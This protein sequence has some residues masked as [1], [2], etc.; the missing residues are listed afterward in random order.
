G[1]EVKDKDGNA[2]KYGVDGS[3]I[4]GADGK[5]AA[6]T[7]AGSTIEDEKGNV[8][9]T[10]ATGTNVTAQNGNSAH[11]GAEGVTVN[12]P[13]GKPVITLV[14][15]DNGPSLNFAKG[16]DGQGTGKIT[17]VANGDISPESSDVVTGGQLYS[18][19]KALTGGNE[20]TF[21]PDGSTSTTAKDKDGNPILDKDG[22]PKQYTL[23]TYNVE[24]QSEFVTNSVITAVHNMN[25]QG[26]KFFHTN[27]NVTKSVSQAK[28]DIDS[29]ASGAYAT[30]VGYQ[31]S[32]S[33]DQSLAIGHGA[34]ASG[35]QSL[36]IGTGNQVSGNHS[37]A[38]G[39]P[40]TVS[41]NASYAYGN[42]NQIATDN[43]FVIGN[44][45]TTTAENSVVL[46]NKSAATAGD[47]SVTGTLKNAKT[48]GTKGTT[49]TAG[50]TG[51]VS[52][53]KVGNRIYGGFAGAKANGALSVG[54]AGNERRIQ[55][56]AA[57]E[58]SSTST[59]AINGSQLYSVANNVDNQLNKLDDKINR[60][61]RKLRGGLAA[62]TAMANIPQVTV[63]GKIA[64]G[65]GIGTYE[66][67]GAVSV[68]YSRMS[69]N[70][71]VILKMSAG[72]STQGT[73]N[74]GA[75]VAFQW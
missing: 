37:G 75:G 59:D 60:N 21:N 58:I 7:L 28:N 56:V 47:G 57:G 23:T 34:T 18:L 44:D 50:T 52:A 14:N 54:A 41:G 36:A 11:Y 17:G 38:I 2:A 16:A 1:T 35:K 68:G 70:G 26:I 62:V 13:E 46:G 3:S 63:P 53:A 74:A 42:N 73:F 45:V 5:K 33:G 6:Y 71:K 39:D 48:D 19:K 67:E 55:N 40:N 30:A 20:I 61:N 43:T 10:S 25:E 24:G 27:D 29:S 31:A 12:S 65:A 22:Q 49:T 4:T 9:A 32:A 8:S 69:D 72:A 51:T 64:V 15:G 66:D